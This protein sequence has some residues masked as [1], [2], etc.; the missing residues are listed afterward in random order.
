MMRML[1]HAKIPNEPFNTMVK[2]GQV[3]P[4]LQQILEALAPEAVYFTE[5]DGR[6][7]TILIVDVP[8]PSKIPAIAE[9]WFLSF[10]AEVQF[11]AVFT[12]ADLERIDLEGIARK[13]A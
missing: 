12:P 10:N 1:V 13:W 8:D 4:K 9:P 6:R 11:H 7:S 2:A 3:G 5:Y